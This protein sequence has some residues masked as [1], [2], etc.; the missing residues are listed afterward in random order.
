LT[1]NRC[2]I[3]P[4]IATKS[5]TANRYRRNL[6]AQFFAVFNPVPQLCRF[7]GSLP[8]GNSIGEGNRNAQEDS[9]MKDSS[10]LLRELDR[11]AAGFTVAAVVFESERLQRIFLVWSNCAHRQTKLDSVIAGGARLL[12]N[13]GVTINSQYRV[14]AEADRASARDFLKSVATDIL[15][16]A[17]QDITLC[18][19]EVSESGEKN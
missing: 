8:C 9:E 13:I 12:G 5:T 4:K 15:T 14:P 18:E 1:R 3:A 6:S 19:I 7:I 11:Y 17:I 2:E 10:E 16:L